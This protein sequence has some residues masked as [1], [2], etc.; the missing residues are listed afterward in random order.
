MANTVLGLD[1]GTNSIGWALIEIDGENNPV[2][3]LGMGSRIIPLSSDDRDQFNKG[4]T[5]TKNRDRTTART[6]RKG[7]D[8]RQSRKSELKEFLTQYNI[9]PGKELMELDKVELWKLRSKSANLDSEISAEQLGRILYMLNQKRGY[10]S[11]RSEANQDKKDTD[12]VAEVKGR[13]AVL[14]E[15]NQT[16]GQFIFEHIQNAD[17]ESLYFR[18]KEMVFPREAYIEEFDTIIQAQH[19]K[20]KFLTEEVIHKLRDEIIFYQRKLKSQ[21]GLVS[22]C[23]FEGKEIEYVKN[24]QLKKSFI[25]PKVTPISSPL[26]QYCKIWE[27]VNNINLKI[28]NPP[29]SK[30]KWGERIPTLEEKVKIAEYLNTHDKLSHTELL[31]IM[32]LD[33]NEVFLNKQLLR[34][35]QGNI[36]YSEISKIL[37]ESELLK[38]EI[39]IIPSKHNSYLVDKKTGEIYDEQEGFQVDAKFETSSYYQLWHTIYSIKEIGECK[40]ALIKRF[41]IDE[42]T[43]EKLAKKIDF[44]KYAFGNKSNKAIRKILPY[45]MKG[46]CYSDACELAGY[47]HSDSLTKAEKENRVLENKLELLAKN[48]LRQPI[49]EKILNQMIHIVNLIVEDHGNPDEIR[50]ELARELK[51][52]KDERN[53]SDKI[54]NDNKKINE[55]IVQRLESLPG[56]PTTKKYIQKYKFIF[57][58]RG[59]FDAKGKPMTLK[60]RDAKVIPVC[61]Y[62]GKTFNL[63]EALT[64]DNFDVDHI[65]PKDL[66]FDDSQTN[67]VLVHRSCNATKLNKTAYDYIAG[68]GD[69]ELNGYLAR[70]DD[71]YNRG[72]I[73]F[74]KM[75]RLKISHEA[76][77]ERKTHGKETESDKKLWENF[78][79]RQLRQTQYISRKAREILSKICNNVTSSEGN[80]T[81]RLRHLWGWDDILLKLQLPKYKELGQTEDVAWT[82]EHGKREHHKEEIINW[83]KRDDHRHHA[84]DALVIACTKQA[85]IQRINT[86]NASETKNEME[87]E[88]ALAKKKFGKDF[89]NKILDETNESVQNFNARKTL[90]DNYL[91]LNKPEKF[92]FRYVKDEV[93]KILVSFKAGKRVATISKYKA[94]GINNEKGVLVPRGALHEQ[95]VY[96]KIKVIDKN[97]PLKFLFENPETIINPAIKSVVLERIQAHSGILKTALSSLKQSPLYMDKSKTKFLEFADCYKTVSVIKYKIESLTEKDL[98]DIV[99]KQIRKCIEAR[100]KQHNGNAK[101]AFKTTVWLNEKKQIPIRTVRLFARPLA[102]ALETVKR[103]PNGKDIG[104]VIPGS[105]HHIA[106]YKDANGNFQQHACTLWHAVERKKNKLPVIIQ[107]T[108]SLWSSILNLDLPQSFIEKL[109]ADNLELFLSMQ[110]NEMFILGL[111]NE[112]FEIAVKENNF[113]LISKHLY[114]VWSLSNND[115]WFR[116][117]LESKNTELKNINGAKESKRYFRFKSVKSLAEQNPIKIRINHLGKITKIGE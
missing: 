68:K 34:G 23:E 69:E 107:D 88:I 12:Y 92:T 55:E 98:P 20:H 56:V 40:S 100:L 25:G 66:L 108:N 60:L 75:Q 2:S 8:R 117:H 91:I 110:Q 3:I 46:Y 26:F 103:D 47:N 80:V 45:L 18:K 48:S 50:V 95:S 32:N 19:S 62:C 51:Q 28:K 13:H 61:I 35:I 33:K 84:L 114:I 36:T 30:Y 105:N 109:P 1:L 14:K 58:T 81:A 37:G 43:A 31:K 102:D 112:E 67:K 113:P 78:I 54:N 104:F 17:A 77:K 44:S 63:S 10:K 76:Y 65:I 83:S 29:N 6:Q 15:K 73:S 27:T 42:E 90:L 74:A 115:F 9:F 24:N 16:I 70:V 39:S 41:G 94:T 49:V 86:L 116:H 72:I 89:D 96:G 11:A 64:G 87:R 71:W 53:D 52:S 93:E 21:K 59:E 106:I 7:Y 111:S 85:F 22:V 101:E 97:K 57:Q 79:D 4:Q 99:D 5:I 82:S 38:F